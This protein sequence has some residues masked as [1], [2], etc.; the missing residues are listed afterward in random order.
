MSAKL[1][2][3]TILKKYLAKENNAFSRRLETGQLSKAATAP[4][5]LCAQNVTPHT[6]IVRSIWGIFST[7][8]GR[9]LDNCTPSQEIRFNGQISSNSSTQ[10]NVTNIGLDNRLQ[11]K[12]TKESQ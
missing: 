6:I 12:K 2:G 5:A 9:S 4:P 8:K 1:T 10:G 3:Q 7:N 11:R